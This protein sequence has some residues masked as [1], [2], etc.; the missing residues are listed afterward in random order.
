MLKYKS[1]VCYVPGDGERKQ[2]DNYYFN[3]KVISEELCNSRIKLAQKTEKEGVQFFGICSGTYSKTPGK[4]ASFSTVNCLKK[5]HA[6]VL[7][8]P[9]S[10]L[11]T[12]LKE[13]CREASFAVSAKTELSEAKSS[14]AAVLL[15]ENSVTVTNVGDVKIYRYDGVNVSLVSEEHTQ[16]RKMVELGLLTEAKAENHP[17]RKK[18]TKYLGG[19]T[20]V[21]VPFTKEITC[22]GEEYFIICGSGTN[23]CISREIIKEVV[24][25]NDVPADIASELIL[26]CAD[27]GNE[28]RTVL[29]IK[30]YGERLTPVPVPEAVEEKKEETPELKDDFFSGDSTPTDGAVSGMTGETPSDARIDESSIS[31]YFLEEEEEYDEDDDEYNDELGGI[32]I[33]EADFEDSSEDSGEESLSGTDEET[34]FDG[35]DEFDGAEV[36]KN[37]SKK[38]R[39]SGIGAALKRFAGDDSDEE[40]EQ[41]WPALVVFVVCLLFII[42]LCVFGFA[43]FNSGRQETP[44]GANSGMTLAPGSPQSV[45]A[46]APYTD[47]GTMAPSETGGAATEAPVVTATPAPTKAPEQTQLIDTTDATPTVA[48]TATAAPTAT[49]EATATA[50]PTATPTAKPTATPT[51]KPTATVKPTATPTVAPTATP[52][53][54]PTMA[55]TETPTVTPS[56][57]P[58]VTEVP[59]EVPT[60]EPTEEP[61]AEPA[62]EA[63]VT[64]GNGE[65]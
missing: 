6:A 19:A 22:G 33:G 40:R 45:T 59:T 13:F 15:G 21:A 52:T 7:R 39:L 1:A 62:N 20:D 11:V 28:D 44:G 3:S 61:T 16:A 8:D 54:T 56:E 14:F 12:L 64:D 50:A 25:K 9:K 46:T 55:P 32:I 42:L 10:N 24:T 53:A 27:N 57:T 48:P 65:G 35:D 51:A 31:S 34:E 63:A 47:G 30:T 26:R 18:L 41:I 29:V 4:R 58:V 60:P 36:V 43:M 49:P 38:E 5:Y 2:S 23:D 17:Q 37:S